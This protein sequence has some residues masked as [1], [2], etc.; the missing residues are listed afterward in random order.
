LAVLPLS[1]L[2]VSLLTFTFLHLVPGDAVDVLGGEN[3]D[4]A[5]RAILRQQLGLDQSIVV[6]YIYWVRRALQGNLGNSISTGRPVMQEMLARLGTTVELAV[7][8]LVTALVIGVAAGAIATRW[9]QSWV[10]RLIMAAATFGMSVPSYFSAT[11]FILAISLYL[12]AFGVVSYVPLA[13][14]VLGNLKS[15][16]FPALSLSLLTGATFCHYF[17]SAAEDILRTTDFVRTARAKNAGHTRILLRHILPNALLPLATAAGLQLAYLLG[18]TVVIESI[19]ALPGLGQLLL[20]AIAQRDY[21][22]LQ[23]CVLLQAVIFVTINLVVDLLYPVLDP[24]L[25]RSR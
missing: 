23:G 24:R 9:R 19:F 14:D 5:G 25:K 11:L 20:T 16:V 21:P 6:Q 3:M 2:A 22:V 12:P 1:L 7:L 15:M 18:G 8:C 4:D 17:R 13:T 10:D